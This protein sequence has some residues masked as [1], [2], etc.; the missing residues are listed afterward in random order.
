MKGTIKKL[1]KNVVLMMGD[2]A[3]RRGKGSK[4]RKMIGFAKKIFIT[5]KSRNRL[6]I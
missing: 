2:G 1:L 6:K 5:L 4:I 3:F